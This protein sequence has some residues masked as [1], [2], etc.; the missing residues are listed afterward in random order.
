[1]FELRL[2][3]IYTLAIS[4]TLGCSASLCNQ[5]F[6]WNSAVIQATINVT[7]GK[8]GV[9]QSRSPLIVPPS[10]LSN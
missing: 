7:V 9:R 10:S 8:S 4:R 3:H 1:M 5:S 6:V 2:L